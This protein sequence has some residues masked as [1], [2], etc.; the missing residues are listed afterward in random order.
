V[1]GLVAWVMCGLP[2]R[3]RFLM[4]VRNVM[5]EGAKGARVTFGEFLV[6]KKPNEFRERVPARGKGIR[7]V[8]TNITGK[9]PRGGKLRYLVRL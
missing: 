5:E 3:A 8:P 2:H 7:T 9:S 4:P 6:P 1:P